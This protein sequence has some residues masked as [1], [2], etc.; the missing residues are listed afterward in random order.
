MTT[1]LPLT[2]K[3]TA[4]LYEQDFNLWLETTAKLLRERSLEKIDYEVL[5]P[6]NATNPP[7]QLMTDNE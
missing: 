5:T 2:D 6:L 4:N 1:Q 7:L 3:S